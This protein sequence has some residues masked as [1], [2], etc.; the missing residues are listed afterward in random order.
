MMVVLPEP[1]VPFTVTRPPLAPRADRAEPISSATAGSLERLVMVIV[2]VPPGSGV[3]LVVGNCL[4]LCSA[5]Q[6]TRHTHV[7]MEAARK[8]SVVPCWLAC[9]VLGG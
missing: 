4:S 9:A 5:S 1:H 7:G 3:T 6:T 8:P 2:A